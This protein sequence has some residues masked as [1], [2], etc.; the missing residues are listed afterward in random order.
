TPA[1]FVQ[2][3]GETF[4]RR[5][6]KTGIVDGDYVEVLSGLTE[7]ERVV[8]EGAYKVKLASLGA[9][10]AIGHGHAH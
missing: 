9:S 1:A 2:V 5:L 6:L 7:G 10:D 8:S 4:A 3:S